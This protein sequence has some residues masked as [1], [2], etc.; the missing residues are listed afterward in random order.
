MCTVSDNQ[1]T[2]PRHYNCL[3]F[4]VQAPTSIAIDVVI[5]KKILKLQ[6]EIV[7][8]NQWVNQ[9]KISQLFGKLVKKIKSLGD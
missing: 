1:V 7:K 3:F 2:Y 4:N 8:E 6:Q 9:R 5:S